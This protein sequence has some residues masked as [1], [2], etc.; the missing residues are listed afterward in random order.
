MN[1]ARK[2]NIMEKLVLDFYETVNT[3]VIYQVLI[4]IDVY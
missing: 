3:R 1:V 4:F 2:L